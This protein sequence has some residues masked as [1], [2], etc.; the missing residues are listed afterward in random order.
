MAHEHTHFPMTCRAGS[1]LSSGRAYK[2]QSTNAPQQQQAAT[3]PVQD[4]SG[5]DATSVVARITVAT[6]AVVPQVCDIDSL[7]LD[8][9]CQEQG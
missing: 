6:A 3:A 5:H 4:C 1:T 7:S 2:L 8:M 9:Q